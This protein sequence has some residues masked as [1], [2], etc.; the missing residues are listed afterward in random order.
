M[1]YFTA[2]P[3]F[4]HEAPFVLRRRGCSS[5]E[6]WNELFIEAINTKVNRDDT[7]WILGDYCF[8]NK[9][10][11]S[12]RNKIKCKN[13]RFI[14]GNHDHR[15][16]TKETFGESNCYEY[17]MI[18]EN[19]NMIALFHYPNIFWQA[20]HYQSYH[21][22]GH[23]HGMREEYLDNLF[24]SRRSMDV[25]PENAYRLIGKFEPFSMTEMFE[26]L[27]ERSGHDQLSWYREN[28]GE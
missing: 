25:G 9:K 17:K 3:H 26:I 2:D 1:I 8:N 15:G 19:G 11:Q 12:T 13:I 27:S 28:F 5:A 18:K 6:E 22:Y 23:L 21:L 16:K 4:Y 10:Y 24:P 20:S 14:F 7:L